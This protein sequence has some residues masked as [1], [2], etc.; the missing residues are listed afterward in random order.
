MDQLLAQTGATRLAAKDEEPPQSTIDHVANASSIP[1][2]QKPTVT[3]PRPESTEQRENLGRYENLGVI[4]KGGLGVIYRVRDSVLGR[5]VALKMIKGAGFGRPEEIER[6]LLEAKSIAQLKHDNIIKIHE[7]GQLDGQPYFTMEI[8]ERGSLLDHLNCFQN[9][10]R[11]SISL[12]AKVA[13]AAHHVHEHH[14]VHRDL[15]PGN[16]LLEDY[17]K[18]V[19]SDFGLAK[20]LEGD[21]DLTQPGD[22]PGTAAY[23]A[24]EQFARPDGHPSPQIDIWALGVIL[25]E[26]LTGQRPFNGRNREEYARAIASTE[27]PKSACAIQLHG[28]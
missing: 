25:F 23:M 12:L 11:A 26:V 9:D 27:P 5:T 8:A 13:R 28:T 6:F 18:P 21:P 1:D 15:K 16:I 2:D 19:V 4:K 24:P 10:P 14:I 3:N 7:F 20:W 22:A 17:D